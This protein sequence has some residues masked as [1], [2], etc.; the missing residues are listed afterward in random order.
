MKESEKGE[1][2]ESLDEEESEDIVSDDEVIDFVPEDK[3]KPTFIS[4]TDI[5][6]I[7]LSKETL[8]HVMV[9]L[10]LLVLF[11]I[12]S[13]TKSDL[14]IKIIISLGYGVTLGYFFTANLNKFEGFRKLSRT[15]DLS[16]LI[17]PGLISTF[18]A[19][20]IWLG[21]HHSVYEENVQRF[22]SFGLIFIFIIWQFAQAWW[23]RI[24]FREFALRRMAGYSEEGQ[25][26]FA[27]FSNILS[28]I[29]WGV[30]GF[31]IFSL[32][33]QNVSQFADNFGT[34]FVIFWFVMILLMG[35]PTFYLLRQMHGNFWYNPKV[36]SFSA[37]FSIGYWG[38]L[39]YHAG[40]LLYSMYN[41][42]SFVFD[43][44]F[45]I[46]TIVLVI[47][48]LSFQALR[49]EVRRQHLKD[50]NH[51]MGKAGHFISK[52]NVIFY[53]ISFTA[54]YGASNF[55]L[56]TADTSLIGGIQGVSRISHLIVIISGII[57]I[58]IVNYNLLTG[59][60]LIS[61]GFFESMRTPKDN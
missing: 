21:L 30:I 35:L 14:A 22:L 28:P 17:V 45:M 53:A 9:L 47:Y 20:F 46:I 24:P 57:V 54:A 59:R 44:V 43:L 36:S 60:G 12:L 11:G 27:L 18:F 26:Q 15:R 49:T 32:V 3:S 58:L 29:M 48:S 6:R 33:A 55:F 52:D 38:F 8:Y 7:L 50:T 19:V 16:S 37:Y 61:E 42:P 25:S 51:Y 40:V 2:I 31:L 41:N 5:L 39:A 34:T 1:V 56:A 10:A 4:Q 23:M 13:F